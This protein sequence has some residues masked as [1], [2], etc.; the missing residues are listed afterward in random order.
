MLMTPER[1][2]NM[3]TER[4]KDQRVETR[5]VDSSSWRVM[6]GPFRSVSRY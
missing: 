1:S 4:G 5:R 3:P 6:S 2:L